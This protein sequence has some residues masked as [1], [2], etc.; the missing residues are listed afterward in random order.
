MT[1]HHPAVFLDR[2]GTLME[3]VHYCNDPAKVRIL[4][5][6]REGL[7]RLQ[8]AGFRN[9]IVTNQSGIARGVIS[10]AQYEAVQ[11]RL[12]ELLGTHLIDA[13]YF[14]AEGPDN[15]SPRRKP[16]PGMLWEARD[17]HAL[18]LTRSWLIGDKTSDIQS[19]VAAG[20]RSILVHTGYG[21]TEPPDAACHVAKDFACAVD[22]I[23]NHRDGR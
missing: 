18:D 22:F 20:V 19:G 5:G 1:A 6:V 13:T 17:A 21:A 2:D 10:L 7:L 9:I 12:F 3:E 15:P 8:Q 4:E 23:L 14:C 11:A 16:G